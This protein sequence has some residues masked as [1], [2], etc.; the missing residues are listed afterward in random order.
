[1]YTFTNLYNY[2]LHSSVFLV[3]N[4]VKKSEDDIR[5]LSLTKIAWIC[6]RS[7]PV[8]TNSREGR[9]RRH[10]IA[11]LRELRIQ[12]THVKKIITENKHDN[13]TQQWRSHQWARRLNRP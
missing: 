1:M 8:G 2:F 4:E 3:L 11:V 6:F 10:L 9:W 5:R 12:G 7:S 13:T